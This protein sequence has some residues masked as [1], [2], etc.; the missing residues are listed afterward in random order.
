MGA[1]HIAWL[2]FKPEVSPAQ[3][4]AHLA[5]CRALV[6]AVPAVQNLECGASYTD[7]ARGFTHAIIVSLASRE[8]LPDYLNHPAHI[9]V[10]EALK[11]D[12]ADLLV[13]DIEV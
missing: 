9:P 2:K 6:G 10:G 3:I 13:M 5:R 7:R 12:L 1:R 4:E 11:A 8:T